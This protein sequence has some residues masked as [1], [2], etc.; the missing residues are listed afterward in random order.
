[1]YCSNVEHHNINHATGDD[2]PGNKATGCGDTTVAVRGPADFAKIVDV[3]SI[4]G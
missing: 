3:S 2:H 4:E 1:M